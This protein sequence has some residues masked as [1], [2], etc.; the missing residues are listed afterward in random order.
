MNRYAPFAKKTVLAMHRDRRIVESELARTIT[1]AEAKVINLKREL[2]ALRPVARL[3]FDLLATIF[4]MHKSMSTARKLIQDREYHDWIVISHVSHHWREVALT[5]PNLWG[6]IACGDPPEWRRTLLSRS[7]EAPLY[8]SVWPRQHLVQRDRLGILETLSE[9]S[10]RGHREQIKAL[11]AVFDLAPHR[12]RSLDISYL[13]EFGTS[14]VHHLRNLSFPE[15]RDINLCTNAES[16]TDLTLGV[17]QFPRLVRL[18]LVLQCNPGTIGTF[19]RGVLHPN[20]TH[21]YLFGIHCGAEARLHLSDLPTILGNLKYL[22]TLAL[23]ICYPTAGLDTS[24][25]SAKTVSFPRLQELALTADVNTCTHLLASFALP[26]TMQR[27][28][29]YVHQ[30]SPDNDVNWDRLADLGALLQSRMTSTHENETIPPLSAVACTS[31]RIQAW[32]GSVSLDEM[33]NISAVWSPEERI[34]PA[35]EIVIHRGTRYPGPLSILANMCPTLPFDKVRVF[36]FGHLDPHELRKDSYTPTDW[37]V[38]FDNMPAIEELEIYRGEIPGFMDALGTPRGNPALTVD[39]GPEPPSPSHS[40]P[41][42]RPR[43]P[44][45]RLL[46]LTEMDLPSELRAGDSTLLGKDGLQD[47][48]ASFPGLR[49]LLYR[50]KDL[51]KPLKSL[52]LRDYKG[53][54]PPYMTRLGDLVGES[55]DCHGGKKFEYRLT[56]AEEDEIT[57]DSNESFIEVDPDFGT[58]SDAPL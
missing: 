51:G 32:R 9:A 11:D 2:N 47:F 44:G 20:L 27:L 16:L 1:E 3:H 15:L 50:R 45:L 55:I 36:F 34:P 58:Y 39:D 49:D 53:N 56:S 14:L 26:T 6:D 22:E 23:S 21:L 29:F 5:I 35:L 38:V 18:Q 43:L 17:T 42:R 31:H 24:P 52:L 19:P 25:V 4:I 8:V 54:Y 37:E 7:R 30:G 40:P 12:I 46:V 13:N 48:S 41:S 57:E 33:K 28:V 10:Q